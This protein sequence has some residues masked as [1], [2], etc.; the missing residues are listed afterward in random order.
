MEDY[1]RLH[2][3]VIPIKF[4][5][6]DSTKLQILGAENIAIC[7]RC[8]LSKHFLQIRFRDPFYS[9][10]IFVLQ[11][12]FVRPVCLWL[13]AAD[14]VFLIRQFAVWSPLL[15]VCNLVAFIIGGL[16]LSR[17]QMVDAAI[18]DW[19]RSIPSVGLHYLALSSAQPQ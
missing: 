2:M 1:Y 13:F 3:R 16:L 17:R 7:L 19:D 10:P 15:F 4:S 14:L 9:L 8:L 6:N 18:R 11:S 5:L 12:I